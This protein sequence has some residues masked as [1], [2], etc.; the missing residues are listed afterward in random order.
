[1][2]L[3][4][5]IVGGLILYGIIRVVWKGQ[6]LEVFLASPA[7]T[8][9]D[10]DFSQ[11]WRGLHQTAAPTP[12]PQTRRKAT[13]PYASQDDNPSFDVASPMM[14]DP[15]NFDP[16]PSFSSSFESSAPDSSCSSHDSSPCSSGGND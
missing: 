11:K 1:M 6:T 10:D 14:A 4:L 5:A 3:F 9:E 16:S 12:R 13:K 8:T 2:E 7:P 15:C